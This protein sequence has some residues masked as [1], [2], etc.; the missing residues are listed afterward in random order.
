MTS[1]QE[2]LFYFK[3]TFGAMGEAQHFHKK[4]I[5]RLEAYGLAVNADKTRIIPCGSRVARAYAKAGK[6]MPTLS[7]LGFMHVWGQS[8]N[9]KRN[10][11]FWRMKRRTDPVRFRKKLSEIREHLMKHRHSRKLIPYT[12]LVVRGYMNYFAVND[13]KHRIRLFLNAVK[14][15]LFRAL[16]RRSEKKSYN[17][18][19]SQRS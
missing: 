4:M 11:V 6:E 5:E 7:F 9:R 10:E 19:G 13:N 16:N 3:F 15:L 18:K 12:I 17:W 1:I 14:R 8:K 2:C